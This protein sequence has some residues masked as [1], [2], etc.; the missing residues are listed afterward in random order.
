MGT[1]LWLADGQHGW[2]M[3]PLSPP[4]LQPI[5]PAYA[6]SADE[7]LIAVL[8]GETGAM[9]VETATGRVW[10]SCRHRA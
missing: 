7:H 6:F 3:R 8:A 1:A 2:T 9:V 5:A 4:L 10:P